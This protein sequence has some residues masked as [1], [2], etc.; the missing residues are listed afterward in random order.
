VKVTKKDKDGATG[1]GWAITDATGQD[2]STLSVG[3]IKNVAGLAGKLTAEKKDRVSEYIGRYLSATTSG[4]L[5]N[6]E[7]FSSDPAP[8]ERALVK[9]LN[10]IIRGR[11]LYDKDR[12]PD[13]K[14]R[15]ETKKH[16]DGILEFKAGALQR[17]NRLLLEDAYPDEISRKVERTLCQIDLEEEKGTESQLAVKLPLLRIAHLSKSV[18]LCLFHGEVEAV[19]VHQKP[20]ALHF[21]VGEPDPRAGAA[22]LAVAAASQAQPQTQRHLTH[23]KELRNEDGTENSSLIL[24]QIAWRDGMSDDNTNRVIDISAL[25]NGIQHIL[26]KADDVTSADFALQMIEGV[27]RVRFRLRPR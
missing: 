27:Q 7:A 16:K 21:G 2:S 14:L 26:H 15:P 4:Y 6:L 25:A 20:E 23:Y 1:I 19:D 18:L 22:V 9:D 12:F 5:A 17:F 3:E 11:S 24:E 10:R 8:L 13:G